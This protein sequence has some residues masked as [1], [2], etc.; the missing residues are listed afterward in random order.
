MVIVLLGGRLAWKKKFGDSNLSATLVG[1]INH[2]TIGDVKNGTLDKETFFGERDKAFLL[3]SAPSRKVSANINYK[4]NK[5]STN[6][7]LT[8]FGKVELIN[9][10][11]E[12]ESYGDR[13]TTD[14]TMSY[15]VNPKFSFT[16]GGSNI[17]DVY[18]Q[19]YNSAN[20]ET[21]SMYE[22]VQM[23]M[24]GAFYFAKV[25]IKF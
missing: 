22:A 25:G 12:V 3:A 11:D 14:I 24:G 2:M 16:V 9:F 18:P 19:H 15:Q 20:T 4:I 21:G 6:V 8:N 23:G 17:L 7:R 13:T 1:N 10:A 5:F